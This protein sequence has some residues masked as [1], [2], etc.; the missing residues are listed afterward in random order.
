MAEEDIMMHTANKLGFLHIEK[1]AEIDA[2]REVVFRALVQE[3]SSWWGSPYLHSQTA[4]DIRFDAKVGGR[5][6]EVWGEEEGA[7]W[8]R[9]TVFRRNQKIELEGRLGMRGAVSGVLIINLEDKGPNKSIIKVFHRAV[10]EVHHRLEQAYGIG[11]HDL[12]SLRLKAYVESGKKYGIGYPPPSDAL[13]ISELVQY[14]VPN[15]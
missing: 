8:G 4:K 15:Q 11:W 5:L 10:G 6:Y 3:T 7:E 2:S 1:E 12:F 9:I 14:Q 13:T